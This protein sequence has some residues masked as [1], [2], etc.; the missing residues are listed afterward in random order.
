MKIV[1]DKKARKQSKKLP[2]HIQKKARKAFKF[3]IKDFHH[4][5]LYTKKKSGENVFEAR[6]DI[7]YRFSFAIEGDT[8]FILTIGMHDTGLGVKDEAEVEYSSNK[9]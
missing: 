8:I 9:N 7:H 1:L 4:P 6:V 2:P 3:L 5:S